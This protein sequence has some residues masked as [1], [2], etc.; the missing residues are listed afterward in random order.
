MFQIPCELLLLLSSMLYLFPYPENSYHIHYAFLYR[1]NSIYIMSNDF[2]I[3][4]NRKK[5]T[6]LFYHLVPHHLIYSIRYSSNEK[7][8]VVSYLLLW[9]ELD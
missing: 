1:T 6:S 9:C 5:Q 3:L 2:F 8:N 4:K 7:L